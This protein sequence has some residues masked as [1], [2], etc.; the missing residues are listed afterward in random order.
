MKELIIYIRF[1]KRNYLI[2]LLFALFGFL[3]G[4]YFMTKQITFYAI[5]GLYEFEHTS[6][7]VDIKKLETDELI[8]VLR[9]TNLSHELDFS[10]VQTVDVYKPGPVSFHVRLTSPNRAQLKPNIDKLESFIFSRASITRLSL[11]ELP[12]NTIVRF[13]YPVV[14]MMV[15]GLFALLISLIRTY[16]RNY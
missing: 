9:G 8:S 12:S 2:I 13:I 7:N 6:E 1:I 5:E 16:V 11:L 10:D 14:G 15:G 3:L 4:F